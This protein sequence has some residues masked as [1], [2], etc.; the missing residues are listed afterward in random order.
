MDGTK[1]RA[2]RS[3]AACAVILGLCAFGGTVSL[4]VLPAIA[5]Q[6]ET[7]QKT[8]PNTKTNTD[9]AAAKKKKT[10]SAKTKAA[11]QQKT[12]KSTASDAAKSNG[13]KAPAVKATGTAGTL[14]VV[15]MGDPAKVTPTVQTPTTRAAEQP[16]T[17]P[18]GVKKV[19]GADGE[20]Q[21]VGEDGKPLA[22]QPAS[23][24][25]ANA[26]P[27]G[28]A[29]PGAAADPG[30]AG[31][32]GRRRNR[33]GGQDATR[34]AQTG[35]SADVTPGGG[36]RFPTGTIMMDFRGSDIANVLKLFAM[37]TN[38]QVI[39]DPNLNG[40]VTII[41]PRSLSIEQAFQ[42][43]QST[44]EV[45]GF[46]GQ[47]NQRGPTTILKIVPLDRAVQG[48]YLFGGD[49]TVA[50]RESGNQVI[51]QVL[52]IENVDARTLAAE[53][54]PL[55]SKGASIVG[56]TGTNAL[57]VTDT[58]SNVERIRELVQLLDKAASNNEIRKYTLKQADATE[59][60]NSLNNLFRQVFTRGRGG[61]QGG[62]GG[63]GGGGVPGQPQPGG[64]P[65][66]PGQQGG[67]QPDRAAIVAVADVRT[68]SVFVVASKDNLV[69]VE[70][71]IKELDDPN[72]TALQTRIIKMRFAD[73]FD[74]ADTINGVLSNQ[75]PARTGGNQQGAS[76][77]QRLFGGGGGFGGFGGFGGGGGQ[78]GGGQASS[79][80][81]ARLIPNGRTNSI[82][83]TATPERME[84]VLLLVEQLDVEVPIETTT[85]VIPL[86]NAQASDLATTLSQA[87][88]TQ[89]NGG[90]FG[91]FGGFGNNFGNNNN[92]N[93]FGNNNNRAIIT[94]GEP[95]RPVPS[96]ALPR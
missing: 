56:S 4:T 26:L 44:L 71:L 72:A 55:I 84:R 22:T 39:P 80:P 29:I 20:P 43:L 81:F 58:A 82:I 66:Q 67:G 79:D 33:N 36:I 34:A 50:P 59:V 96:D 25:P 54:L 27:G 51:T 65:G 47:I 10:K 15:P 45:R 37:A 9:K 7:G 18:P 88:G 42:V 48:A 69:R 85:F 77:Q 60:A 14:R 83:V 32:A 17:L 74:V 30:A 23:T 62:P 86:K 93:N 13:A 28:A 53:I 61:G 57:I 68:N 94:T 3:E 73:A 16:T 76:F 41:S 31:G 64:I 49:K 24:P 11:A 21:L 8:A 78:Q 38:W 87:F 12:T 40:P 63:A 92:R 19:P 1:R 75:L 89:Q 46:T 5:Q 2:R 6:T 70:Q 95:V 90:G 52:P 35:E 91:G